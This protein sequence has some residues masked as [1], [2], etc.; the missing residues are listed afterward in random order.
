L[1]TGCRAAPP[2]RHRQGRVSN[3]RRGG[4]DDVTTAVAARG[5]DRRARA[6]GALALQAGAQTASPFGPPELIEAAKKEGTLVYY[7]ANFTEVEQE[8]IKAFNKR[9]PFIRVEMIR[10]PAAS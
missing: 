8:V 3:D 2:T 7:T 4:E 9:F 10:A 5:H 1:P 6:G